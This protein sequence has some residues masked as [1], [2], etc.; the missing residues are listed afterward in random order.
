MTTLASTEMGSIRSVKQSYGFIRRPAGLG[1]CFF[2][3]NE[4]VDRSVPFDENL[5]G[6]ACRYHFQPNEKGGRAVDVEL[7]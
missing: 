7:V 5:E 3:V 1:D 4:L 2:H 6:R